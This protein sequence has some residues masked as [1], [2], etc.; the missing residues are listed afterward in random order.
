MPWLL[1]LWERS[2]T[3]CI[4]GL[5]GPRAGLTYLITYLLTHLLTHI[6]TYLVTYSLTHTHFMEQNPSW[7][8]NLCA[9]SQEIPRILWNQKV[10]YCIQKCTPPAPFP[11]QLDPVRTATTHFLKIH[12]NIIL[13]SAPG[14]PKWSLSLRFPH[15]NPVYF[16]P[17]YVLHLPPIS[18]LHTIVI[19]SS[20]ISHKHT[21]LIFGG[22]WKCG[23]WYVNV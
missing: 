22:Y 7:E 19:K 6:F 20:D 1:Y 8:A 5:V 11:S 9:A 18:F 16:S 17:P 12:L 21:L 4:G 10:Y 15:Q 14:S 23:Q 3:C 2:G 13:P